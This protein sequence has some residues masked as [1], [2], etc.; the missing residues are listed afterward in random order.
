[1]CIICQTFRAPDA[2]CDYANLSEQALLFEGSDAV[3]STATPYTIAVGDSFEGNIETNADQDWIR[4]NL[5]A[6]TSYTIDMTG[7]GE[8]PVYDSYLRLLDASGVEIT[9]NDDGG[10]GTDS[11]ITFTATSTGTY[12]IEA[13]SFDGSY[14]GGYLLTATEVVPLTTFSA[15]QIALQLTDGYWNDSGRE[16]RA[17]DVAPGGTLNVDISGLTPEG[18]TLAT[19][20]LEVWS[21]TTGILFDTNPAPEAIFHIT[22]DDWDSGAYCSSVT[23]GTDIVSSFVNVSTDWLIS[24]GSGLVSYSFQTYIHE[25][26][27]ALG[28]GHAGNYN[29]SATYGTDNHYL[30][31]SWQATVMSYFSQT[32]NTYIDATYAYVMTPM[33][34]D[35][36]A[37]QD[38]YGTAIGL[39]TGNTTY[40]DN[41]NAGGIYTEISQMQAAGT[42]TEFVTMTIVDQGG[43]DTLDLRSDSSDVWVDLRPEGISDIYGGYGVLSIARGTVLEQVFTGSGHDFVQGNDADN[44]VY[45]GLG[46]DTLAGGSGND[47]L[48]GDGDDDTIYL[49]V[50]DDFVGG[51]AGND[52]IYGGAG[53]NT[54]HGG[55]GN[56]TVQGGTG[57]DQIFGGDGRNQLLGN[58]GNDTITAGGLGDLIGGGVGN[59]ALYGGVGADSIYGGTGNDIIGAGAGADLI[60]GTAGYN[61]IYSGTGADTVYG[62]SGADVIFGDGAGVNQLFGNDG[63]D[64]I[65]AGSSG[66][67]I[68]GGI[69]NDSLYGGVGNDT[70]YLGAGNDFVGGGAG[71]DLIYA[72]AGS[73]TIYGGVGDDTITAGTGRDLMVGSV[74]A[75][76]FVFTSAANIG[77]GAGRD[78]ISDFTAGVD[79][80]NLAALHL[81]F[82]GQA[83]FGGVAGQLRS[84]AG[85]V[86]GDING[87]GL[88]DFTIELTDAGALGA[89]S[90][91]L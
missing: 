6:G 42:L 15:D 78:V 26:G 89:N 33:I 58:D 75:D 32:E 69:G 14:A 55:L 10:F 24:E 60:Y 83:A 63:N 23:S 20:A 31:D 77:L 27:H 46:R 73:N 80:I 57:A 81:T 9:Y 67:F 11:R 25:L 50:G 70:I 34:A 68:A 51:G 72:G 45:G 44:V 84:I 79:H 48:Y 66:D 82:I 21:Q 2:P 43:F 18:Q 1:M 65:T 12:Y 17:F 38:L 16:R 56:D 4:I 74:G 87:D 88:S 62:G 86:T 40:G 90:F 47:S 8:G 35:I 29:G 85:F 59:D 37:M 76:V 30:N 71:N 49:G 64:T 41:S 54:I 13:S 61:Q 3:A 91:I 28:L 19:Y 53:R 39:R 5:Q 22:M 36:L 52:A 7:S